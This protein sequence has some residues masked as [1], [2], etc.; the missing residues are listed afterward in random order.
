TGQWALW[1]AML[2]AIPIFE[3]IIV[4]LKGRAMGIKSLKTIFYMTLFRNSFN[5]GILKT[6]VKEKQPQYFMRRMNIG[7]PKTHNYRL[8]R[9]KIIK[10]SL[11]IILLIGLVLSGVI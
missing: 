11:F 4:Y 2:L 1:I 5:L 6:I 9:W 3:Y 10:G 7:A 8:N